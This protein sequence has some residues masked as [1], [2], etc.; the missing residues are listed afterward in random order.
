[1]SKILVIPDNKN[2]DKYNDKDISGLIFSIKDLSVNNNLYLDI[3]ELK[4]IIKNINSKFEIWISL[5][6]IM[7]NKDLELL[8][9]TL[10]ELL[11]IFQCAFYYPF[12]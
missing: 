4:S 9:N 10:K 1:M 8:E 11:F 7:H 2:I 3:D 12:I 5:N 6:K